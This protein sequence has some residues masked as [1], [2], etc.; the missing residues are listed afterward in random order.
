MGIRAAWL[1]GF[2][3]RNMALGGGERMAGSIVFNT[4]SVSAKGADFL[5]DPHPIVLSSLPTPNDSMFS[6]PLS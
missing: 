2:L 5:E 3:E 6:M 1:L 4:I